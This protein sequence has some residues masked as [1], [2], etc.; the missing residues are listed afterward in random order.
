MCKKTLS[1][2]SLVRMTSSV[3]SQKSSYGKKINQYN[4]T[5]VLGSGSYGTVYLC[6]SSEDGQLYAMKI[7]KRYKLKSI[8][9]SGSVKTAISEMDILKSL[10]H[11]NIVKLHEIIDDPLK[12]KVY[13]VMDYLPNGTVSEKL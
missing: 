9:P 2:V 4:L 5:K 7:I 11:T 3:S 10:A 8:G 12:N 13:L 6:E 1:R